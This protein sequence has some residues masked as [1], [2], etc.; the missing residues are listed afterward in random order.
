MPESHSLR[1]MLRQATE[2]L[3]RELDETVSGYELRRLDHYIAFLQASAGPLMALEELL[4][5]AD[6]QQ[7]LSD[8]SERRRSAA[9]LDDL[10]RL[11]RTVNALS[12]SRKGLNRSEMLGILYVLEGS[13][14]GARWLYA[15]VCSSNDQHINGA[16]AYLQAH[17]PALWRSF[18]ERLEESASVTD[19]RDM[20]AGA[21]YAFGLFLRS[22]AK[23]APA[24]AAA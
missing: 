5:S 22:F 19:S 14:L 16:R 17:D 4:E 6:V 7:L 3:H 10:N 13:R 23:F 20:I 11:D 2:H 21:R 12:L 18:L 1:Q 9:V 15:R 8:W 24:P